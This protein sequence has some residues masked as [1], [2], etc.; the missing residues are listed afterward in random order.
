MHPKVFVR[1]ICNPSNIF[2]RAR[3]VLTRNVTE[4][5]PSEIVPWSQRLGFTGN[6][7]FIWNY[8]TRSADRIA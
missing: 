6:I 7:F 1:G 8:A 4:Y 2:A 3:L 5:S